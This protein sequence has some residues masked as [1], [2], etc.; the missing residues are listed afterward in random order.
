[1]DVI[2]A[3]SFGVVPFIRRGEDIQYLLIEQYGIGRNKHWGFPKG[4]PEPDE[5]PIETARREF[6]EE[7]GNSTVI[8]FSEPVFVEH[9]S[10]E[11]PEGNVEKKV[12]YYIGEVRSTDVIPQEEEI[13]AYGWFTYEDAL[14]RFTYENGRHVLRQ[15]HEFLMKDPRQ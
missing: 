7:T 2:Q 14:K 12:T 4:R 15:V 9:Y 13:A 11:A 1:M 5:V 8:V 3:V 6:V 10:F